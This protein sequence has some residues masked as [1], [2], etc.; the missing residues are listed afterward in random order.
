MVELGLTTTFGPDS[1]PGCQPKLPPPGLALALSITVLVRLVHN[2][3]DPLVVIVGLG[4][5]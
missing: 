3:V 5:H 2:V 1:G 4:G